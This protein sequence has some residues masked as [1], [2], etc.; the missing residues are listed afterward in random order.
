MLQHCCSAFSN[1]SHLNVLRYGADSYNILFM[2]T[3][4]GLINTILPPLSIYHDNWEA[5]NLGIEGIY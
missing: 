1:R 2:A 3:L 4:P 5:V